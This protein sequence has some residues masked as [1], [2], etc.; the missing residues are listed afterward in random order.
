[1][2]GRQDTR[3]AEEAGGACFGI[4]IYTPQARQNA[5]INFQPPYHLMHALSLTF[6][7]SEHANEPIGGASVLAQIG[8]AVPAGLSSASLLSQEPALPADLVARR[9]IKRR[10]V[11]TSNLRLT[12]PCCREAEWSR[13]AYGIPTI[14]AG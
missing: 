2:P 9:S 10:Q 8:F 5:K 7:P 11:K 13:A 4:G 12:A 1:V 3:S 14:P 6:Y